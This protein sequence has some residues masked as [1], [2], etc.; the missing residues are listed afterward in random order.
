M[1]KFYITTPIYYANAKPHVGHAYTTVAADVFARYHELLG[2]DVFFLTG[3]DEHGVKNA[4]AAEE[5]GLTPTEFVAKQADVFKKTWKSLN[6]G[7]DDFIRT[8]EARHK[9]S[10]SK[11]L[12]DLKEKEVLYKS[13]Y[14]GLYCVGCEKFITE[15]D[16]VDGKCP[17]HKKPPRMVSEENWFFR[18]NRF[19]PQVKKMVEIDEIKILPENSKKETLGLLKQG[20]EDFSVSREKVSWGI[21]VPFDKSE[22]IYVWVEA[23][24]NYLSAIGYEKKASQFKKFWPADLQLLSHDILKFHTVFWPAILLAL[25]LPQPKRLFIHGYF[26]IDGQK[27]S[28]SIGNVIDPNE[29]VKKFDADGTRYLLLSQFPFSDDGDVQANRFVE[30]YNADLANNLGNLVSRVFAMNEKYFK[31]IVPECSGSKLNIQWERVLKQVGDHYAGDLDLYEI[32]KA[33]WKFIAVLNGYV[34]SEKPW[35]LA[36]VSSSVEVPLVKANAD[37][38]AAVIFSLLDGIYKLCFLL[39]P[40]IPE[41]AKKIAKSFGV[42]KITETIKKEKLKPGIKLKKPAILFPRK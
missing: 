33:I 9:S 23:L 21:P 38:L 24:H 3:T 2:E 1:K 15:K 10:A 25:G 26:T 27:M 35:E 39:Y 4:E 11:F 19:L 41:T 31:G 30:K 22:T 40:F 37:K 14:E 42:E 29:L 13:K 7:Y 18:L 6:I 12:T 16:L 34:D 32:L 17:D 36:K 8:D 20:L 5:A 28:K